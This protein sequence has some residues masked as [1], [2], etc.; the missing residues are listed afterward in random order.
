VAKSKTKPPK[1][2][3][4]SHCRH[5]AAGW[6]RANTDGELLTVCLLDREQ[7]W[8]DMTDCDRYEP[9]IPA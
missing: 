9:R 5:C 4:A 6:T 2:F 1:D 7:A 3:V 8:P